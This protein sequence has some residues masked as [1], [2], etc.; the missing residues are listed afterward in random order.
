MRIATKAAIAVL[1]ISA[2]ATRI[3]V[4]DDAL[5][6]QKARELVLARSSALRKAELSVDEA[7][8]AAQSQGYACLPSVSASAGGSLGYGS[9]IQTLADGAGASAKLSASETLFDGGKTQAL[10]KKYGLAT[11]AARE[12]LRE[13]RVSLIGDAD[14]AFFSTLEAAASVDAAVSDLDAAK[15]RLQIAQAKAD[16]G[17]LSKSDYLQTEAETASYETALTNAQK[18]L[19]SAKAK[20]A[21]LTGLPAS[22]T[23]QQI[24]FA[25]YDD[26]M[27]E[28][29]ALD[30]A[31]MDSLASDMAAMAKKNSPTLNGLALAN[32]EA[33]AAVASAKAAYLP[34]VAAGFS[35]GLS[36]EGGTGR[37]SSAGS[38]SVT[39]SLS[40]DLW[41]SKNAVASATVAAEQ[42]ELDGSEGT[43]T[44]E[45]SVAQAVYEWLASARAVNSSAKALDYAQSN[46]ENVLEKFKLSAATASDLST[47]EAL[48][49][50]DKTALIGARYAFLT[51]LSTLRGYAGLE[52]E[53]AIL[54][55]LR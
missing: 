16:A 50:A 27:R 41:N 23:L 47:A 51:D 25:S 29:S 30:G 46:Y 39:A 40:L 13:T 4:A 6:I 5:T 1:M 35:Q 2:F 31:A 9:A 37:L 55:A 15:L 20:L 33:K 17:T 48:V 45:L 7:S 3:A 28:L 11:E 49:S 42:A 52:D 32:G 44:L 53:S 18:T 43:R 19:A 24:D 21:S 34:T 12:A 36:Y 38:L 10:V 22:T 54:V 8:L 26:L 14:S